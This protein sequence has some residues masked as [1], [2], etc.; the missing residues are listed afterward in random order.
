MGLASAT[1][2]GFACSKRRSTTLLIILLFFFSVRFVS[3]PHAL[4]GALSH[5]FFLSSSSASAFPP[6]RRLLPPRSG[7]VAL[8]MGFSASSCACLVALPSAMQ[9]DLG[10]VPPDGSGPT[11][12]FD[13]LVWQHGTRHPHLLV[14][15]LPVCYGALVYLSPLWTNPAFALV[16]PRTTGAPGVGGSFRFFWSRSG[17][18]AAAVGKPFLRLGYGEAGLAAVGGA[19]R[20]RCELS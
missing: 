2:A 3:Q 17:L 20:R 8:A 7:S 11:K 4:L 16:Q 12:G 15:A 13:F 10:R 5:F 19:G 18:A 1:A 6:R 14:A 9:G